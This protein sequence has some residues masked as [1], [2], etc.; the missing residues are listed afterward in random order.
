M[1]VVRG[2]RRQEYNG[3]CQIVGPSPPSR[4]KTRENR[5][6]A[7]GIILERLREICR[8]IPGNDRIHINAMWRPLVRERLRYLSDG[9]LARGLGADENPAFKTHKR[10]HIDDL[11]APA[12]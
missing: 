6:I 5:G 12:R 9:T 2:G 8:D 1:H 4:G 10:A 11:A 3:A 7:H